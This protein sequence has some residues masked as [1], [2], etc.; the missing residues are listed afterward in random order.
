MAG[1]NTRSL[2][3]FGSEVELA[4]VPLPQSREADELRSLYARDGLLVARGLRLDHDKQTEFCRLFGPVS[5]TPYERFIVS[6]VDEQG[7]LG[8]R[9][10]L[11]H[12]DVPYLPSPYLAGCLHA[13]HVDGEVVGTRFASGYRA[14]ERLPDKLR[15]RIEG[16]KA[17]HVRERAYDRP[18]RLTD[19]IDG[20][21]CTV[22]DI[23]RTNPVTGRKYLFVNEA[24]TALIIGLPQA[25][26]DALHAEINRHF[27]DDPGEIYEHR[28][29]EG[30][31]VLWDNLALQH[32]RG[33]AG[34]GARTLQRVT[35]TQLGYADQYPTDVG[36]GTSLGN[37]V[38]LA[39]SETG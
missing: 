17:L 34:N 7:H 37:E 2:E 14:L 33:E 6:N 15:A 16:M 11:W 38:M 9:E 19:L 31:L 36:I 12:N 18:N 22:H 1:L 28:W 10:L 8:T 30:D 26:S 5:E 35:I 27:Y 24:W 23:V 39:G 25:E 4:T 32:A 21:M 20:D 13:V 3:P 29:N